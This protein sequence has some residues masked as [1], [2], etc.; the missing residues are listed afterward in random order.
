MTQ[1]RNRRVLH[2]HEDDH[3]QHWHSPCDLQQH[4]CTHSALANWR[5]CKAVSDALRMRFRLSIL[6]FSHLSK[7]FVSASFSVAATYTHSTFKHNNTRQS[8]SSLT[9]QINS[10]EEKVIHHR[11]TVQRH[12]CSELLI[13]APLVC[14]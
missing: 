2:H 13:L 8:S 5:A 1:K 14:S 3:Q 10:A 11:D 7:Q 6:Q 4:T 12:Q 9:R